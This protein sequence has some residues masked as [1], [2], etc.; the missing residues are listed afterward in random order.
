M[1]AIITLPHSLPHEDEA[2]ALLA[3]Q[4]GVIIH[5]RRHDGLEALAEAAERVCGDNDGMLKRFCVHHNAQTA[6][7]HRL[8]G[9]HRRFAERGYDCHGRLSLSCHSTDEVVTALREGK[10]DYLFLSPIFDSI[11]KPGYASLFDLDS[12]SGFLSTLPRHLR[13]K[14][15][16]LGGVNAEN[17]V[18][19]REAGF[20]GAAMIGAVWEV[21]NGGIDPGATLDNL[22]KIK[23]KWQ[24]EEIK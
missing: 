23:D 4:E 8:G 24:R 15:V 5:L 9:T 22:L 18:R 6:F 2:L 1:I 12:L 10:A 21:R 7:R 11:S 19:C 14:V 17:M 16:A 3:A 13:G 20:G